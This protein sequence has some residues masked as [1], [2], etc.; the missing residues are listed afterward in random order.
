MPPMLAI[1]DYNPDQQALM[2]FQAADDYAREV[3]GWAS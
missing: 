2:P 3:M 1:L